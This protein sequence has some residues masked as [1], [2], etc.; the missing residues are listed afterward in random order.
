MTSTNYKVYKLEKKSDF[1]IYLRFLI[2]ATHKQIQ[3]FKYYIKKLNEKI[4]SLRLR[5]EDVLSFDG[6][7][8]NDFS[9]KI[10]KLNIELLNLLADESNSS[11]SYKKFRKL[12]DRKKDE[13]GLSELNEEVKDILT[14]LNNS[15]NWNSHIPE[16]LIY[17]QFEAADQYNLV[18]NKKSIVE[19]PN[20]IEIYMYRE[21]Q[22]EWLLSLYDE[23]NQMYKG[24][25]KIFQQMKKD[26]SKIVGQ[27]IQV[28]SVNIETPRPFTEDFA[29]PQIS[30]EMQNKKYKK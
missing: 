19:N 16:S 8:Y 25:S 15:R 23:T 26:Y 3:S 28:I 12:I 30:F 21:Y 13:Y 20:P 22:K 27:S 24:Y 10:G 1:I 29:I 17:A 4:D 18:D 14:Q 9:D 7:I 11:A 2:I 6:Y 5:D